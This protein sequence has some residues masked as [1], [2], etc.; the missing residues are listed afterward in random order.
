MWVK[1]RLKHGATERNDHCRGLI[2]ILE[3]YYY[4]GLEMSNLFHQN[5][6]GSMLRKHK[7]IKITLRTKVN[8][9]LGSLI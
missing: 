3:S 2:L 9:L 6:L 1:T 4:R 8:H 7:T 5:A